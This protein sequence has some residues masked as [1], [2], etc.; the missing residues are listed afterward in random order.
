MED[1]GVE[2]TG[3]EDTGGNTGNKEKEW[4]LVENLRKRKIKTLRDRCP[5]NLLI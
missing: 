5:R 2:D 1:T 3:V 4:T